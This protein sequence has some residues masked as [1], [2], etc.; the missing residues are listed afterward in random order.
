ME[1][2]LISICYRLPRTRYQICLLTSSNGK[3]RMLRSRLY[4]TNF[5][6]QTMLLSMDS[7][8]DNLGEQTQTVQLV[9]KPNMS[10]DVFEPK[11]A[12]GPLRSVLVC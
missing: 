1:W 4:N 3:E 10:Y 2:V 12:D 6:L 8:I 9:T 11:Q 5:A 7:F